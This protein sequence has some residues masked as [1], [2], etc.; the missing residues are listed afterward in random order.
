MPLMSR[1]E[2]RAI[3]S[4]AFEPVMTLGASLRNH[5]SRAT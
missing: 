5:S 3:L 2:S 4:W 1:P